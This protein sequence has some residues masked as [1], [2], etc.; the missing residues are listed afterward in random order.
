V[1]RWFISW[2]ATNSFGA[3]FLPLSLS[4]CVYLRHSPAV[5]AA[6]NDCVVTATVE[7]DFGGFGGQAGKFPLL[8]TI[9]LHRLH[10]LSFFPF[11]VERE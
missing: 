4:G 2:H 7:T 11:T 6:A 8:E 3:L 10:V 1:H 9:S 5:W